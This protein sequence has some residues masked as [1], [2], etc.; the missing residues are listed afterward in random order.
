MP[1]VSVS[2]HRKVENLE[3]NDIILNPETG[4]WVSVDYVSIPAP[5]RLPDLFEVS[6]FDEDFELGQFNL[7]RGST[8]Q[9]Y[10]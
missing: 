8:V 5:K 7:C 9:V 10:S 1:L 3:S 4:G 6:W 2:M